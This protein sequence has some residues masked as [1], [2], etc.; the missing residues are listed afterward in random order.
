MLKSGDN[1]LCSALSLVDSSVHYPRNKVHVRISLGKTDVLSANV[2]TPDLVILTRVD[3]ES[4]MEP[5]RKLVLLITEPR[6]RARVHSH[7][8]MVLGNFVLLTPVRSSQR[9]II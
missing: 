6:Y 8:L 9:G 3:C 2:D 7:S 1:T 5:L 4:F